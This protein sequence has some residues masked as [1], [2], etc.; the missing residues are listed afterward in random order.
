M[1]LV[2]CDF[3]AAAFAGETVVAGIGPADTDFGLDVPMLGEHPGMSVGDACSGKPSLI[4]GILQMGEVCA[5]KIE[6]GEAYRTYIILT[7]MEFQTD[8]IAVQ[9]LA[10]PIAHLRLGE[11]V[12]PPFATRERPVIKVGIEID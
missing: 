6:V 11:P 5:E 3:R 12:F 2:G 1:G 8:E 7:A 4:A 9:G 10:E